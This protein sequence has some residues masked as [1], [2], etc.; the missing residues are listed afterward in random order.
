MARHQQL[1]GW[2]PDWGWVSVCP[3]PSPRQGGHPREGCPRR[4]W[5]PC[6]L[7]PLHSQSHSAGRRPNYLLQIRGTNPQADLL[8][9]AGVCSFF[10]SRIHSREIWLRQLCVN[11]V[12][13]RRS[14]HQVTQQVKTPNRFCPRRPGTLQRMSRKDKTE[15]LAPFQKPLDSS[16]GGTFGLGSSEK[17]RVKNV[18]ARRKRVDVTS[19]K[20]RD[21]G[22][23]RT[24]PAH[25]HC[26][27][28][29]I[30]W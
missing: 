7:H 21:S 24:W 12:F 19:E 11:L 14:A 29:I 13:V 18:A 10:Q 9:V 26:P 8:V 2:V 16:S 28:S 4:R 30:E 1:A 25:P 27:P 17:S 5:G 23:G 15:S 22:K 6:P 3:E 20:T